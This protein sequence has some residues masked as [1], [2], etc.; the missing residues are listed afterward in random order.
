MAEGVHSQL[1]EVPIRDRWGGFDVGDLANLA[2]YLW[3][4]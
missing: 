1:A 4:P 2:L 3:V